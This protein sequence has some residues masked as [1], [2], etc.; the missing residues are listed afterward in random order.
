MKRN[1]IRSQMAILGS[2]M[3]LA[4]TVIA[5]P[6]D[7]VTPDFSSG[8]LNTTWTETIVGCSGTSCL[9]VVYST[10]DCSQ[11]CPS[12]SICGCVIVSTTVPGTTYVGSSVT[13]GT[14]VCG[15]SESPPLP[16]GCGES[17][18]FDHYEDSPYGTTAVYIHKDCGSYGTG[19][20]STV[21]P[22]NYPCAWEVVLGG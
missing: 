1:T 14:Y 16:T 3:C 13:V 4:P 8:T 5:G 20:P 17:Y 18:I 19:I 15:R 7:G 11:S 10:G 21:S 2:V 6:C 12:G 9:K 22:V